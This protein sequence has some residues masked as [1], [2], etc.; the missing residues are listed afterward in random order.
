MAR[1]YN[2][3]AGPSALPEE[4]LREAASE[5]VDYQGCGMSVMEMSHRSSEFQHII[6][7]TEQT[8][9]H[10][11]KLDDQ[12]SV[13]FLQGGATLE[14]AAVPLN[15]MRSGHAGYAISGNFAKK[16]WQEAKK[17]G[18]AIALAS[19]EDDHFSYIPELG[20][21]DPAL[22]YVHIC[23]NNTIFGTM[24]HK[25]PELGNVPLVADVSSCFLSMPLDMSRY[26]VIYA[27]AQ[28]NA[29][30]A[31]TT[32]VCFRNDLVANGPALSVCPTYL[33]WKLQAEKE[34]MY[35]TPNCWGIYMS[36]K[37]FHWIEAT[38]GLQA[39]QARNHKKVDLLYDYL[40][41][42][43]LFHTTAK[44]ECRSIANVVF[45]TPTAKL[46]A[47]FV[48]GAKERGIVG[49]K[50]H[51]LVGGMRA[52]CY[53]AVPLKAVEALLSYMSEFEASHRREGRSL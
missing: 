30:P 5:M 33:N 48:A 49:I 4:V 16:A 19:S 35:N 44:P 23:Q 12:W 47:D 10:L 43:Q 25:L 45:R 21:V 7:D 40:D 34:S 50:G 27:G 3:A 2:F 13:L 26:S 42:A 8:L 41:H 29:G 53:N 24:W 46:D 37:V 52:S 32:V 6:D 17:Y 38:G 15:L 22:D 51:R 11:L 14:F 31:G 20:K 18:E 39:M 36:G 9:R 28:K 1:V